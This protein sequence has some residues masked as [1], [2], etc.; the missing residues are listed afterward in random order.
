MIVLDSPSFVK[1]FVRQYCAWSDKWVR[2]MVA[3]LMIG[4][5]LARGRRT[6]ANLSCVVLKSRRSRSAVSRFLKNHSEDILT[7]YHRAVRR[8]VN[9]A[10]RRCRRREAKGRRIGRWLLIIDTTFQR[11]NAFRMDNLI[12]YREKSK[13]VPAR[14]HGFV[15][16]LLVTPDGTR[17]PLPLED[18]LT[19][20]FLKQINEERGAKGEA[21][22]PHRTQL[23][24]AVE[25]VR[26]ARTLL[27]SDVSLWVVADNFFEGT[28]L[29]GVCEELGVTY[30]TTLDTAR[31]VTEEKKN[32]KSEGKKVKDYEKALPDGA[33]RR[34]DIR[35]GAEP[36]D[37]MRRRE[38]PKRK[39]GRPREK[40]YQVAR[41][42]LTVNGLGERV[43]L[44]SWKRRRMK[45]NT[46]RAKANL[47]I[48]ITNN[49]SASI[50]DIVDAYI[51][52]WQ[53]ELFFRELKSDLGLGHYQVLT[54]DAIRC[55][56]H[57]VLLA[58]LFLEMYRLDKLSDTADRAS[59]IDVTGSRTRQLALLVESEIREGEV[60][61][62]YAHPGGLQKCVE[63]IKAVILPRKV[64]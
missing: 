48:L 11:K 59:P 55:H 34:V 37:S 42:T 40:V 6:A 35:E 30:V 47:R 2:I 46:Q 28:K 8:A 25:L 1:G 13:G 24:L 20:A 51:M 4:F 62:L 26:H 14:N 60:S 5:I 17:I 22:L 64:A 29:D 52:R 19:H 44:F 45:Y 50:E 41:R 10:L 32:K 31:I 49:T 33:F 7:G 54:L 18:F 3:S 9:R 53:I 12:Q 27:P 21:F 58:F 61:R 36:L 57:L 23:D 15:T 63:W 43:V 38:K 16:G 56:V 39:P